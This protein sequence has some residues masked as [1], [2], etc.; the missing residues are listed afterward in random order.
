MRLL[1]RAK[2]A[3]P[4]RALSWNPGGRIAI[5]R[6]GS[7][8]VIIGD[9]SKSPPRGHGPDTDLGR[10]VHITPDG[11]PAPGNPFIGKTRALPEIWSLGYR[12]EEGLTID[13]PTGRLWEVEDG[14][15]GRR[16]QCARSGQESR[17]AGDR[18]WHRLSGPNHRRG[19]RYRA[20]GSR[21]ITGTR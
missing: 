13:P 11:D 14:T 2:S 20:W 1:F 16:T 8:F 3:L 19:H 15:R 5:G 7:L 21:A 17:L 10:V 18:A 4:A 12:T 9:R 6:D